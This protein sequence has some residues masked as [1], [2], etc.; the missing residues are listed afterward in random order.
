M[1]CIDRDCHTNIGMYIT[2][3]VNGKSKRTHVTNTRHQLKHTHTHTSYPWPSYMCWRI[4]TNGKFFS[5]SPT[6][7]SSTAQRPPKLSIH[8]M[9]LHFSLQYLHTDTAHAIEN[10]SF[11]N[12]RDDSAIGWLRCTVCIAYVYVS[13]HV[14]LLFSF[15]AVS[16]KV[17][18]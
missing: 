12:Q 7:A 10:N 1:F 6:A 14:T 11:A 13:V 3:K 2:H 16:W 9:A 5:L 4:N 17:M 8:E 15:V 18:S